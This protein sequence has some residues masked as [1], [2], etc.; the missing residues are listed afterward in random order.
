[1]TEFTCCALNLFESNIN[2]KSL[3]KIKRKRLLIEYNA[4]S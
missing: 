3:K 4:I 2:Y 1:M